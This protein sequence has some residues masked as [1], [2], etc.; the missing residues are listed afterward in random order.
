MQHRSKPWHALCAVSIL[1]LTTLAS[2]APIAQLGREPA[3]LAV[4]PEAPTGPDYRAG[5]QALLKGDLP[6]AQTRFEKVLKATPRDVPA[7]LAMAA[8]SQARGATAET[9][10]FLQAAEKIQPQATEVLLARGRWLLTRGD[11]PGAEKLFRT[12][13]SA[14]PDKMPPLL[15]LAGVLMRSPARKAEAL[16]A[17]RKAVVLDPRNAHAQYGLGVTAAVNGQRDEALGALQ[18][19][20]VLRPKDPAAP[21][22]IGKLQLEAGAVDKA[23]AAFDKALSLQPRSVALMIDRADALQ[24]AGRGADALKQLMV[25]DKQAPRTLAV[26]LKLGDVHLA[27]GRTA[28]AQ[29]QYLKAIEI[30]AKHPL[31]YNNLAWMTVEQRGDASQAVAW[32]RQAV[33]LAP[34]ASPFHDT[35]GWAARAA[36]RQADAISSVQ[37]AIELDPQV[38]TYHYHL[39]VLRYENKQFGEARQSLNK[40][41]ALNLQMPEADKAKQMLSALPPT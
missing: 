6:A 30:D 23:L 7:L 10:K 37:R 17:Y 28:E 9:E 34:G 27:A 35:L 3:T 15:D 24:L 5:I 21:Q 18:Q 11:L 26:H 29:V 16:D 33:M 38:A 2:A 32:A 39:G 13:A 4:E 14:A 36:G 8:V 41:L 22:A 12:A 25:A 40:A 19:A 31:A 1:W 20:A